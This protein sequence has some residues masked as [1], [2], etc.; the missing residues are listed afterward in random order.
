MKNIKFRAKRYSDGEWVY[1]IN[2]LMPPF[3]KKHINGNW[4]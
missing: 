1:G 2:I 4:G 3:R